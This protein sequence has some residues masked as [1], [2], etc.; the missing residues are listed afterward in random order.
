M[1]G[2]LAGYI[3]VGQQGYSI[4]PVLTS[5]GIE[6]EH[7]MVR[8]DPLL[9]GMADVKDVTGKGREKREAPTANRTGLTGDEDMFTWYEVGY[10]STTSASLNLAS[11]RPR[12]EPRCRG[13]LGRGVGGH[14]ARRGEGLAGQ[15]LQMFRRH[16]C[17]TWGWQ[18]KAPVLPYQF[19][20]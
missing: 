9:T 20:L 10:S 8:L 12:R 16:A 14:R 4:Q 11:G 13:S 6:S 7:V 17:Q 19:S 3:Q 5:A 15:L 2:G 18:F 1:C